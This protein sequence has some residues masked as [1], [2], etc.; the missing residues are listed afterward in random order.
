MEVTLEKP[1]SS[2]RR[3]KIQENS[4]LDSK[5][6]IKFITWIDCIKSVRQCLHIYTSLTAQYEARQF[7]QKDLHIDQCVCRV[8]RVSKFG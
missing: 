4:K 2:R 7:K 3:K 1:S 5:S 8:L 6:N